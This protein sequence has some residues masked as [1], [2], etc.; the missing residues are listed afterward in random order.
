MKKG[1][2]IST[3]RTHAYIYTSDC[4]MIRKRLQPDMN[5]GEEIIMETKK[6]EVKQPG[7]SRTLRYAL[8][9]V[10]L[11]FVVSL[12]FFI[13][14]NVLK[15]Q[16]YA[17][18][19][20]DVNP[21]LELSL[22][23][24]LDVVAVKAMNSEAEGLL[25]GQTLTGL[26]WKDAVLLWTNILQNNQY[27]VKTMLLSAVIPDGEAKFTAA[28]TNMEGSAGADALNGIAVRVLYSNDKDVVEEAKDNALSIGRQMLLN[29]SRYQNQNWDEATIKDAPLGELVQQLLQTQEQNQTGMKEKLN[30][31]ASN[32]SG[33]PSGSTLTEQNKETNKASDGSA[34]GSESQQTK[35]ETN[36][37]TNQETN[38][39]SNQ[40]TSGSAQGSQSQSA[41]RP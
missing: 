39:S 36:R 27:D 28:L 3:D 1:T 20:I 6:S 41:S 16:V 32:S 35:Q 5:V 31:S 9:A 23:R 13:G 2:V 8:I 26:N 4:Q 19:S 38:Q 21:S 17:K 29:Q 37:E 12:G 40:E 24:D 18:L 33:E 25:E 34:Q 30:P 10:S 15:N 11:L 14:Q 22:N 7:I